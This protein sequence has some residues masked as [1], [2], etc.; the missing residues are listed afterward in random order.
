ME[1]LIGG[2]ING[3]DTIGQ[4]VRLRAEQTFR[5]NFCLT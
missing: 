1:D 4:N 3:K 2:G 5:N